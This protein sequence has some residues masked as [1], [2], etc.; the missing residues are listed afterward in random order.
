MGIFDFS[1]IEIENNPFPHFVG[2]Q[3]LT[4]EKAKEIYS[5]LSETVL[6]R[7]I[8]TD[9]YSQFEFS[10]LNETLP[11]EVSFL[12]S[13][14]IIED[15]KNVLIESFG[16]NSL[17]LVDITAHKL[18]D[19]YKMG[20]HNDFVGVDETHRIIFQFNPNWLEENGG[21]LMLFKDK[22]PDSVSKVVKPLDNTVFGFEISR[23]SYHAVSTIHDYT[24]L[25][26]VYTF[27]IKDDNVG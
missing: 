7:F 24:R 23:Q 5:W 27:N 19:G 26:L 3:I 13:K 15:L 18:L 16:I 11:E 14:H 8:E 22:T 9:F 4:Q 1:N 2:K 21:Y 17:S 25:T 20:I 6:W 10:L 12:T